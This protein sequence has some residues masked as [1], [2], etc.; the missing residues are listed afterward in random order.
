MH[1]FSP[2]MARGPSAEVFKL[3]ASQG[4]PANEAGTPGSWSRRARQALVASVSQLS[5]TA[6]SAL[7]SLVAACDED[8]VVALAISEGVAGPACETLGPLLSPHGHSRL[9]TVAR[10]QAARN[11]AHL[12]WLRKFGSALESADITWVVLKGPVLAEVSYRGSTHAATRT[13]T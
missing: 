6:G 2:L 7:S 12:A 8:E 5:S 1:H 10:Q 9:R 13:S 11:L 4:G 3:E